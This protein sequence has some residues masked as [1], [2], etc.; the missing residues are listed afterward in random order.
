MDIKLSIFVSSVLT[1]LVLFLSQIVTLILFSF[2]THNLNSF[3][4]SLFLT[5]RSELQWIKKIELLFCVKLFTTVY[6]YSDV[7][8][9]DKFAF[10]L[11]NSSLSYTSSF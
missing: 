8:S 11:V 9:R 5:T 10:P 4:K 7:I 1:S 6:R 2:S 3:T